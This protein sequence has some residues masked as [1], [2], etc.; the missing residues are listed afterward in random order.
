M[1]MPFTSNARKDVNYK[2]CYHSNCL[3]W[4]LRDSQYASEIKRFHSAG[5]DIKE[6]ITSFLKYKKLCDWKKNIN[7]I[8]K[9][10]K[11]KNQKMKEHKPE[12]WRIV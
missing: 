1:Y 11:K 2:I 7:K 4:L 9:E 5:L 12:K 6:F 3:W 10:V 8:A